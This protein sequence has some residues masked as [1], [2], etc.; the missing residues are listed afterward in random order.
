MLSS[1]ID[2]TPDYHPDRSNIFHAGNAISCQVLSQVFLRPS[3]LCVCFRHLH[4]A[5]EKWTVLQQPDE[6][7]K[8]IAQVFSKC[9]DDELRHIKTPN[10]FINN[11]TTDNGFMPITCCD[12]HHSCDLHLSI[13]LA[14][15]NGWI[16]VLDIC[17]A[18]LNGKCEMYLQLASTGLCPITV[19]K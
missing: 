15:Q 18:K 1:L 13:Y 11:P 4:T 9:T 17:F 10:Y 12:T 6:I 8:S 7:S 14:T 3:Q 19:S 2:R 16:D 5:R